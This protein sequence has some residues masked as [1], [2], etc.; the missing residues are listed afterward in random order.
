[1]NEEPEFVKS[2]REQP[3]LQIVTPIPEKRR[4]HNPM[5]AELID[6]D[7]DS[8]LDEQEKKD[9]ERRKDKKSNLNS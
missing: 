3:E 1:M 9:E 8:F 5:P 6:V 2:C 7:P 4:E